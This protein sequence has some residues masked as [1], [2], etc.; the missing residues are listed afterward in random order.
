MDLHNSIAFRVYCDDVT[1]RS[2]IKIHPDSAWEVYQPPPSRALIVPEIFLVSPHH[3]THRPLQVYA[4]EL[5]GLMTSLGLGPEDDHL[6]GAVATVAGRRLCSSNVNPVTGLVCDMSSPRR[7]SSRKKYRP[8]LV[9]AAIGEAFE[10]SISRRAG[11][12]GG[13]SRE[14]GEIEPR[15]AGSQR[16]AGGHR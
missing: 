3:P 1:Q 9:E 10:N 15:A 7:R 12:S 4:A 5:G 16:F 2:P 13:V 8:D 14:G 11:C 6:V